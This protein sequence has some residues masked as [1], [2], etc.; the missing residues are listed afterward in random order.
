MLNSFKI[1]LSTLA[2]ASVSPA[3]AQTAAPSSPAPAAAAP[4]PA[5]GNYTEDELKKFAAAAIEINKIQDDAAITAAD[6]Q[7]KML[8]A[9]QAS[10][11][12]P[13]RF[14]EIATAAQSDPS[15]QQKISAAAAPPAAAAPAAPAAPGQ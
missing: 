9:V 14:N 5:A 8:A 6:K 15:L 13:N 11:L 12:D 2:V 3:L 7:P 4:A 10:G 1:V